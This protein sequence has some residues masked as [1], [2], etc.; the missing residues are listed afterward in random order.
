[1]SKNLGKHYQQSKQVRLLAQMG[2]FPL[3]IDAIALTADGSS[4]AIAAAGSGISIWSVEAHAL[5]SLLEI[6]EEAFRQDDPFF[7]HDFRSSAPMMVRD[8]AFSNDGTLVAAAFTN[9]EVSLWI[10]E[11]SGLGTIKSPIVSLAFVPHSE[12]W[13]LCRENGNIEVWEMTLTRK[14]LSFIGIPEQENPSLAVESLSRCCIACSPD[15]TQLAVLAT[16]YDDERLKAFSKVYLWEVL[17]QDGMISPSLQKTIQGPP[18]SFDK[19][20][21]L[22]GSHR[23]FCSASHGPLWGVDID[24]GQ[25]IAL[26]RGD[27]LWPASCAYSIAPDGAHVAI[28]KMD[29]VVVIWNLLRQKAVLQFQAHE[30]VKGEVDPIGALVWLPDG[31]RLVTVGTHKRGKPSQSPPKKQGSSPSSEHTTI[32]VWQIAPT[33]LTVP[34]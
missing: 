31:K 33:I 26:L 5:Q 14:L 20:H 28:A 4:L 10:R 12:I 27:M 18:D 22:P 30:Q 29:G 8:L 9:Q 19:G 32:K 6:S 23:L 15:G 34:L 7:S 11:G 16:F 1:M 13:A 2:D 24:T 25:T 17:Q 21:Y 3:K